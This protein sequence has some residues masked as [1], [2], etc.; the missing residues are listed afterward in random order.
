[1]ET[2]L[3]HSWEPTWTYLLVRRLQWTFWLKTSLFQSQ[4]GLQ[5]LPN[6][7]ITSHDQ[8]GDVL[9]FLFCCF[10]FVY[11][12][13]LVATIC[14]HPVNSGWNSLFP[15]NF[16]MVMLIRKCHRNLH[17]HCGDDWLNHLSAEALGVL[18]VCVY[19]C[20][21]VPKMFKTNKLDQVRAMSTQKWCNSFINS[22]FN[23]IL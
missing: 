23:S 21:T 10:F 6:T 5:S 11:I 22:F 1:M 19:V 13:V 9:C 7:W 14:F 4:A 2:N 3:Q 18:C 15:R 8:Y 20:V 16:R 17:R 12:W